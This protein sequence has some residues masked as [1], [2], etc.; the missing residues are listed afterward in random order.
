MPDEMTNG[1]AT[2]NGHKLAVRV[3]NVT[4][5]FGTGDARTYALK[6]T[7]FDARLGEL[8]LIVGPSGCGKTTLLSAIAG[9]LNFDEGEIE[10]MGVPLHRAPQK[11]IT[12]F[13]KRRVGFIFQSFNLIPTLTLVENVSVPLLINGVRRGDAEKKTRALLDQVG[14]AG[15][16]DDYPRNLSGGQQQRVAIARALVHEPSLLICD[17]PTSALDRETGA[18]IMEL[19]RE[20]ARKPDR[21]VLVVTH[22]NR[23]F[24]YADRMAEMEDGRVSRVHEV[25]GDAA[26]GGEH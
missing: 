9:T 6:S 1:T 16:G 2:G 10:S 26:Q 7:D 5:T 21:C 15:R 12:E 23:V 22:D 18:K 14:L 13:R 17:E 11:D 20:V 3:R 4:K 8:L 19:L 24:Q 25:T